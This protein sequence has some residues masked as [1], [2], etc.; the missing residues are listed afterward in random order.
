MCQWFLCLIWS[1]QKVLTPAHS[2]LVSTW[3]RFD[4]ETDCKFKRKKRS[5]EIKKKLNFNWSSKIWVTATDRFPM[6]E[7][8]A[9][10]EYGN[11]NRSQPLCLRYNVMKC[12]CRMEPYGSSQHSLEEMSWNEWM[13]SVKGGQEI[14]FKQIQKISPTSVLRYVLGLGPWPHCRSWQVVLL[15]ECLA[16]KMLTYVTRLIN[17]GAGQAQALTFDHWVGPVGVSSRCHIKQIIHI[18]G[19]PWQI[20][21]WLFCL[22]WSMQGALGGPWTIRFANRTV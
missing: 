6:S 3:P 2:L 1:V 12:D 19:D 8:T 5:E 4:P 20:F 17:L 11:V 9:P 15:S 22:T 16:S 10:T 14:N 21:H 18:S 7:L 13:N